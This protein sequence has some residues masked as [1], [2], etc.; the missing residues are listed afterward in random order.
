M[1]KKKKRKKRRKLKKKFKYFIFFIICL[2]FSLTFVAF[3]TSFEQGKLDK[4]KQQ[5][6]DQKKKIQENEYNICLNEKYN[7][8]DNTE[9]LKNKQIELTNY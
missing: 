1:S 2:C 9:E 6:A 8:K 7:D 4:I 5:E 3:T